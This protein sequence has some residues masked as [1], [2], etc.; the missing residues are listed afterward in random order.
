MVNIEQ[1]EWIMKRY[2]KLWRSFSSNEFNF[3]KASGIL[4][5]KDSRV[6]GIILSELK[7]AGWL[8]IKKD[9]DNGRKRLYQLKKPDEAILSMD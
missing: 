5:E 9:P 6:I 3:D 1:R 8:N 7:K 2:A 4:K